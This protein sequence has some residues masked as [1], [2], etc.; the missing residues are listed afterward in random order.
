MI[1]KAV[2]SL[3]A[4]VS[5]T[6]MSTK[7]WASIAQGSMPTA[8]TPTGSS[9]SF[10]V[11]HGATS[12]TS[13]PQARSS[14]NSPRATHQRQ[15][16]HQP[17]TSKE[18]EQLYVLTLL[19]DAKLHHEM[20]A[21]RR[22][23]FPEKL[24]KVDAH[25]TLFHA[26]PGSRLA[27]IKR[28]LMETTRDMERFELKAGRQGVFRMS[29]GV[30]IEVDKYS[31]TRSRNLREGLRSQWNGEVE[32][33]Q[34]EGWLSEQDARKGWKGHYTVMNKENDK[35]RMDK[36]YEEL[37]GDWNGGK[38][39]VNGL[40][41]WRYDKGWWRKTEDFYFGGGQPQAGGENRVHK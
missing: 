34:E 6:R 24:L 30:G 17:R 1:P 29:K 4:H 36:C 3:S 11:H 16:T 9:Q 10:P 12:S 27:E 14:Q 32:G 26:L 25:I 15:G 18:E 39:I 13:S 31:L 2:K 21:L 37:T 23:W 8:T 35:H 5:L 38:G 41:L 33:A 28:D 19:T 22:T 40:R 7:S 20:T